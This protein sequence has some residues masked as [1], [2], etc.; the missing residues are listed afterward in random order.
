ML[1]IQGKF[2]KT[3]NKYSELN[4]PIE[5]LHSERVD[6]QQLPNQ[7][8]VDKF[9]GLFQV[10]DQSSIT[11]DNST[12]MKYIEK[13]L[14]DFYDVQLYSQLYIGSQKQPFNVIFD[15]GSAWI[16]VQSIDCISC[17]SVNLFDPFTSTTFSYLSYNPIKITYGTGSIVGFKGQDQVC[18]TQDICSPS[19]S[20]LTTFQQTGLNG[21]QADGILGLAPQNQGSQ[22]DMLLDELQIQ[23]IIQ[24]RTFSILVDEQ[25][26]D[27][28]M[29]LGGYDF[30]KYAQGNLYWHKLMSS[31]YWTLNLNQV[32]LGTQNIQISANQVII[33][34]GTSYLLVPTDDY[35]QITAY[36][37]QIMTL[38][39]VDNQR[40]GFAV[41]KYASPLSLSS[42][43]IGSINQISNSN[44]DNKNNNVSFMSV[45]SNERMEIMVPV[46][47]P[48]ENNYT[49][50][51]FIIGAILVIGILLTLAYIIK[52]LNDRKQE[53]QRQV[54]YLQEPLL[55]HQI[56]QN[57]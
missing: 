3:S 26:L 15:T 27:S 23:G 20:F 49:S 51:E 55:Q 50:Q 11:N 41:S 21:L 2:V 9:L 6:N 1:E 48:G 19:I 25:S 52:K 22:A 46:L 12:V 54:M 29:T 36:F 30:I 56:Y 24:N 7:F 8:Q 42:I 13:Q 35:N 14:Y 39:D 53:R 45:F 47:R 5:D 4:R 16:W 57:Q 31:R 37:D 33:D 28:K 44:L 38:F 10:T 17:P 40:I 18:L 32:Q 34:S 43:A